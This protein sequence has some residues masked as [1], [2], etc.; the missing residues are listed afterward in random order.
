MN[1]KS[2][3]YLFIVTGAIFLSVFTIK[4]PKILIIGDSI[5]LGYMSFVKKALENVATIYHNPGNA[6]H[7]GYGLEQIEEWLG[8]DDWDVVLF[9]WSL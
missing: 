5:S 9:N 7:T 3:L 6:R 2:V 4:I 1:I 8:E